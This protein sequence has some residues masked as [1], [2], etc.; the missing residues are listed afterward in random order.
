MPRT[1]SRAAFTAAIG[2]S[3]AAGG[4][5]TAQVAAVEIVAA[6]PGERVLITEP[7]PSG[8]VTMTAAGIGDFSSMSQARLPNG[9]LDVVRLLLGEFQRRDLPML[10][11][12]LELDDD[13]AAI[14]ETLLVDYADAYAAAAAPLEAALDNYRSVRRTRMMLDS[15][16]AAERAAE[17]AD[18]DNVFVVGGR[19]DGSASAVFVGAPV[20]IETA[21]GGGSISVSVGSSEEDEEVE[22]ADPPEVVETET[23]FNEFF[24]QMRDRMA[25]RLAELEAAGE[26]DAKTL[27]KMAGELAENRRALRSEFIGV[28]GMVAAPGAE[29][30]TDAILAPALDRLQLISELPR[31]VF[32]GESLDLRLAGSQGGVERDRIESFAS[33]HDGAIADLIRI[34]SEQE[35]AREI[36]GLRALVARDAAREEVAEG[37]TVDLT[38]AAPSIEAWRQA[39]VTEIASHTALRDAIFASRDASAAAIAEDDGIGAD[40]FLDAASRLAFPREYRAYWSE[41]A[42]AAALAN[43][44]LT[45]Q[46]RAAIG[47]LEMAVE[48]EATRIRDLSIA[49]RIVQDPDTA[50]FRWDMAMKRFRGESMRFGDVGR[51]SRDWIEQRRRLDDETRATL[52]SI[53][54][55]EAMKALP[56]RGRTI[57][58]PDG[59]TIEIQMPDPAEMEIRFPGIEALEGQETGGG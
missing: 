19:L 41:R 45:E 14:V 47:E 2:L 55:D 13:Q 11:E 43:D 34:R 12:I 58:T 3:L 33:S 35:I 9:P 31:G 50:T 10:V 56:R 54:G 49:D 30:Q 20:L 5:A 53:L 26:V 15:M 36:A 32:A 23:D 40:A 17:G 24:A 8:V 29:D 28:L 4:S 44:G 59:A 6:Q 22:G 18:G 46:Q 38:S 37:E 27:L 51:A 25:A 42:I 7:V 16:A 39:G 1:R 57:V 21:A 52:A 48:P